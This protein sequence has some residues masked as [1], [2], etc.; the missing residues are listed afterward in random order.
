MSGLRVLQTG[1]GSV[2]SCGPCGPGGLVRS[3]RGQRS[4]GARRGAV[5]GGPRR[6]GRVSP[7][8]SAEVL[9]HRARLV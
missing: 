1:V 5:V 4:V 8:P 6:L 7:V 9:V 2:S 3:G